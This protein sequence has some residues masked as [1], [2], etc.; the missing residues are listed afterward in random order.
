M[1]ADALRTYGAFVGILLLGNLPFMQST[2]VSDLPY[3]CLLALITIYI[4]AHRA[5]TTNQRQ[6]ISIKVVAASAFACGLSPNSSRYRPSRLVVLDGRLKHLTTCYY[7]GHCASEQQCSAPVPD[8]PLL[9]FLLS[10]RFCS[11]MTP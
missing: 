11:K 10:F 2:D 4:G 9:H 7:F 1:H 3:F 5:L 6:M 8:L